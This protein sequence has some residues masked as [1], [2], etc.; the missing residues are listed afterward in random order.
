MQNPT[1]IKKMFR[2]VQRKTNLILGQHAFFPMQPTIII[3][4]LYSSNAKTFESIKMISPTTIKALEQEF[5]Y[6]E[7]TSVQEK[8]LQLL[9]TDH[10]LLVKAKTGT[11]KT[12]AFLIAALESALARRNGGIL[13]GKKTLILIISPTRE[14][15]LQIAQEA[16]R[17]VKLHNLKV[18]V[19]V[20]GTSR[21]MCIQNIENF[22]LDI[23][24]GT[25]GRIIDVLN[26]SEKAR[27][28]VD[29]LD[30]VNYIFLIIDYPR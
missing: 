6:K 5:K 18:G 10:D 29:A 15:A 11:G 16:R 7:M 24:V 19:A 26:S 30:T 4:K 8:V 9:P 12:L 3:K 27:Q 13:N 21:F 2:F 20:G 25:P 1:T 14:L 17:L 28:K 23:L 22:R